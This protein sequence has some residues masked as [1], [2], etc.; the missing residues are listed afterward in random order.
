M[1]KS[2]ILR[3]ERLKVWPH[4]ETE[5]ELSARVMREA[6][7]ARDVESLAVQQEVEVYISRYGDSIRH[8][9]SDYSARGLTRL[10]RWNA[11]PD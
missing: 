6:L 5:P 4:D 9:D 3:V 10:V 8:G 7:G 2:Q 11:Q 1:A